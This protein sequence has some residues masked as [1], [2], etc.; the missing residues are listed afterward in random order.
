[1]MKKLTTLLAVLLAVSLLAGATVCAAETAPDD[2]A[3]YAVGTLESGAEVILSDPPMAEHMGAVESYEV[4][5]EDEAVLSV[6]RLQPT[7]GVSDAAS[8]GG[9]YAVSFTLPDTTHDVY[10]TGLS[11]AHVDEVQAKIIESY[12]SGTDFKL[13]DLGFIDTEKK[14]NT[15]DGDDNLCWAAATSNILEYTG[16]GA[17]AGFA[18][19]DELF[20]Q[21]I[22]EFNDTGGHPYTALGWFF[23]GTKNNQDDTAAAPINYPNSGR[24]LSDYNYDVLCSMKYL[25]TTAAQGVAQMLRDLRAGYGVAL[26]LQLTTNG[27]YAGGHSVTLWGAVTDSAYAEDEAAHY[28]SLF[29]TDSDSDELMDVD[30]RLAHDVLSLYHLTP[31]QGANFSLVGDY[32][33]DSFSFA[34]T[35]KTTAVLNDYV[36][37]IPYSEDIEKETDPAATRDLVNSPDLVLSAYVGTENKN[38]DLLDVFKPG[39]AIRCMPVPKNVGAVSFSGTLDMDVVVT[40]ATGKSVFSDNVSLDYTLKPN[41][42][43]TLSPY[44]SIKNL[45]AGNYTLTCTVNADHSAEEA[46]YYNN[47]FT[48]QFKVGNPYLLGD[49]DD[50]GEITIYD[51][52]AIQRILAELTPFFDY[53][54]NALVRADLSGQGM[55]IFCATQIQRYLVDLPVAYPVGEQRVYL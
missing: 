27:Y 14:R 28:V 42:S 47:S 3:L 52:T 36:R 46:Y 20:E 49:V 19:E 11:A 1:M 51:V 10:L 35:A 7:R 18:D 55:D 6:D 50:D 41:Y 53:D 26:N 39:V 4:I 24:Y 9:Y 12:V 22:G 5:Y 33:F 8:P 2:D 21:F 37:L 44:L 30:R 45:P 31:Y 16:W 17:V 48:H 25:D 40:D 15:G 34:I 54:D 32:T 43:V 23:N 13:T 38:K 29:I